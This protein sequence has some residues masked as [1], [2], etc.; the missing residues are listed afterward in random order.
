MHE[1]DELPTDGE[2]ESE[3]EGP[4]TCILRLST[5]FRACVDTNAGK[6]DEAVDGGVGGIFIGVLHLLVSSVDNSSIS[7][8]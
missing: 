5:I 2:L 8:V 7:P 4:K 3:A 6:E 1:L